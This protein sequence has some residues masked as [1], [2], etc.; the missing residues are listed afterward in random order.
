[1]GKSIISC[2]LL[3]ILTFAAPTQIFAQ[4]PLAEAEKP[5]PRVIY[6][7]TIT[8][9][10]NKVYALKN[11]TISRLEYFNCKLRES[12]FKIPFEKL[13]N[14]TLTETP[15]PLFAGYTLANLAW[16]D[17]GQIQVYM[18]TANYRVEGTEEKLGIILKI[19]LTE[20]RT[21]QIV[22][23]KLPEEKLAVP[24][25]VPGTQQTPSSGARN[26]SP[27][28]PSGALPADDATNSTNYTFNWY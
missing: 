3:A 20:I 13:S 26:G 6:S 24:P 17:G 22:Q 21:I 12:V 25:P 5:L 11:F 1:M 23:E 28:S 2:T 19:P 15:E 18:S 27:T 9:V 10:D 14:V 4:T 8:T 7:C 16:K